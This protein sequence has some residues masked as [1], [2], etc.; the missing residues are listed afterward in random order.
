MLV[1][2]ALLAGV[3]GAMAAAPKPAALESARVALRM[4]D[5]P[6]AVERLRQSAN[7]GSAEAQLLLGLM[8]LNA[9]DGD[10]PTEA[11]TW[12]HRSL[13]QNNAT[14]AYV[15][16]SLASRRRDARPAKPLHCCSGR[17]HSAIRPPWKTCAWAAHP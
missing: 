1:A 9:W 11:E 13:D 17:P 4:R 7:A 10:Q 15:L 8:E 3:G 2:A 14:A 12:L 6:T 5:Y 16:A